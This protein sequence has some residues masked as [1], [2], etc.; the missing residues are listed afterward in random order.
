MMI[1]SD[2][3]SSIPLPREILGFGYKIDKYKLTDDSV[4]SRSEKGENQL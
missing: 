2:E 3:K 4:I 1:I